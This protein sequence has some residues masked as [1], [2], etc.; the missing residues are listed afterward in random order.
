MKHGRRTMPNT[1]FVLKYNCLF[2]P[3]SSYVTMKLRKHEKVY[4]Q[5][6]HAVVL[7]GYV[8]NRSTLDLT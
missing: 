7:V 8:T 3:I 6:L 4:F 5:M 1:D 2:L